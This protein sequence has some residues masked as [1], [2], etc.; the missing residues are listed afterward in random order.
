MTMTDKKRKRRAADF[1]LALYLLDIWDL[2]K[3][4]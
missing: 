1:K 2:W 3:E 4:K